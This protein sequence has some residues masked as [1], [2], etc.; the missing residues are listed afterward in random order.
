MKWEKI[1]E[2]AVDSGTFLICD[3]CYIMEE[4]T[5]PY[6]K[7]IE[8]EFYDRIDTQKE[9]VN[10]G[11]REDL[12]GLAVMGDTGIGDGIFEVYQKV[13]CKGQKELKI[14]FK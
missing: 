10:I 5:Q 4:N 13:N 8:K 12:K 14:V 11:F 2:F 6:T 7:I 9:N 1:G 3:P